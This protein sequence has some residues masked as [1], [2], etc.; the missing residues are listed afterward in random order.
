MGRNDCALF[1]YNVG[2]APRS[3]IMTLSLNNALLNDKKNMVLN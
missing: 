3:I 2:I 1:N